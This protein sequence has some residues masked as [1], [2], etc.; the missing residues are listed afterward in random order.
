MAKEREA[1]RGE[2]GGAPGAKGASKQAAGRGGGKRRRAVERRLRE[3]PAA[4]EAPP[5]A[6]VVTALHEARALEVIVGKY[7]EALLSGTRL[8]RKTPA[9]LGARRRALER[10]EAAW[11]A[12]RE[13]RATRAIS[14]LRDESEGLVRDVSAAARYFLE[15]DEGVQRRVDAMREGVGDAERADDLERCAELLE[16]H[17]EALKKAD[18]PKGA[19]G[20]C[21]EL[22]GELARAAAERRAGPD[23]G[24]A[25]RALRNR[26]YWHLRELMDEIRAAG[27]YVFRH[28]P[29]RL[30]LFGPS[31]AEPRRGSHPPPAPGSD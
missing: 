1:K 31:A 6:S 10:A 8:R 7:G 11:L 5:D 30:V 20:L 18:L 15:H 14:R 23:E 19:S 28:E 16:G 13:S 29:K 21:R 3:L 27:R 17:A 22:S 2:G 4:Y 24:A 12:A 25:A 9:E 26:A